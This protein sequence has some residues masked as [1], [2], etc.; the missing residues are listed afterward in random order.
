MADT[1]VPFEVPEQM[2]DFAGQS[3]NQAQKAFDHFIDATENAVSSLEG[4]TSA[5]HP[6]GANLHRQ[7]LAFAEQNVNSA[8]E[9]AQRMTKAKDVDEIIRIQNEYLHKQMEMT[10]A[11][12]R[13]LGEQASRTAQEMAKKATDF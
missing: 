12:M 2:R 1:K 5:V 6:E 11:Q 7:A 13:E 4:A 3:I 8:F 10:G 9:M